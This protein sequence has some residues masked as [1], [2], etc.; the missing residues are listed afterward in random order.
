MEDKMKVFIDTNVFLDYIE[1]RPTYY[2]AAL[3]IFLLSAKKMITLM[4]SDLSIANS[5]YITRKTIIASDFYST[6]KR[7]RKYFDIVPVGRNVVDRALALEAK[8]FEDALQFYAAEQAE[9]DC[10][11]TRNTKHFDFASTIEVLEPKDF[12]SKYFP[13]EL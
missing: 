3:A 5:K 10:V 13:E 6:I 4:L 1:R 2:D 11:V 12:L 7:L 8:D 9:A